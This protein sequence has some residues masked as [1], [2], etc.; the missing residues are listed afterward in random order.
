MSEKWIGGKKKSIRR[1][2]SSQKSHIFQHSTSLLVDSLTVIELSG[3]DFAWRFEESLFILPEIL[4]M[5]HL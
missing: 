1:K 3:E 2:G 4:D 5:D